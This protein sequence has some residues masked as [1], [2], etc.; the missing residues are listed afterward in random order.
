MLRGDDNN[1]REFAKTLSPEQNTKWTREN[2]ERRLAKW[3]ADNHI[4][5]FRQANADPNLGLPN[6]KQWKLPMMRFY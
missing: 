5:L 1:I 4:S 6:A 2:L 3:N